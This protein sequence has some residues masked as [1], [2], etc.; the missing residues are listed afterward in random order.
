MKYR[1]YK[2]VQLFKESRIGER[3]LPSLPATNI[4]DFVLVLLIDTHY[5]ICT[6][7]QYRYFST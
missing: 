5:L 7:H 4:I 3:V 1:V 2:Q 6:L